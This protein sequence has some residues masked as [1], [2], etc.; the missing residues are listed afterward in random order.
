MSDQAISPDKAVSPLRRRMIEDMGIR[1]LA[2]KTQHVY[3]QRVKEFAAF[4]GRSPDTAKSEDVRAFRLR[5]LSSG[6]GTS[7]TNGTVAAARAANGA[8]YCRAGNVAAV[9]GKPVVRNRIEETSA[10]FEA[11]SAPRS[12]PT[13]KA[14][15]AAPPRLEWRRSCRQAPVRR[16]ADRSA[17]AG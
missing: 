13:A 11:R 2:P 7:K 10:S 8:G 6:P 3:V 14:K 1:K 4:L 5:L 12:R 9:P 17:A 16:D 15:L